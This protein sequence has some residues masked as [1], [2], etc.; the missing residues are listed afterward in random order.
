MIGFASG[1]HYIHPDKPNPEL[2]I[3]EVGVAP[4]HR[5][6]RVGSALLK[7]LLNLGREIGCKEAWVLTDRTN[8]PA[9]R[10]YRSSGGVERAPDQVMFSFRL[11]QPS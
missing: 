9:M 8:T 5:D 11:T 6:R 2:W 7:A 10:L 4:S 3:N 1:V